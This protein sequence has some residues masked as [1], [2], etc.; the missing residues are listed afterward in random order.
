MIYRF[1]DYS[2][3]VEG[4]ELRRD[5]EAIPVEPQVFGLLACLIENRERVVS[6][7]DLI[8]AVWGG[9]IVSEAT[10]SS[11]ISFARQAVGDSGEAQAVIRTIPRR[12][13]RFVAEASAE[14]TIGDGGAGAARDIPQ[15][16]R[17]CTTG[18]EVQLAYSV[19]GSGP[20]LLKVANW[21]NHLEFDWESP[22]WRA[23]FQSLASYRQL[24][25]YDSRGVGLSDWEVEDFSFESLARDLETVVETSDP[26]PFALLGISQGAAVAIDYAT[27]N[28][29]R[30][31]HLIL[32]G[33]FAR[34]RNRRGNQEEAA[35]AEAFRT[36][37]RQGW[38]KET[39]VFRQMFASLYLPDAND[40]QVRW[41]TDMQ[42]IATSP[43]NAVR[44]RE[45][46]DDLDVTEKLA[47]VSTPTLILHS[48]REEVA[49]FSEARFMATR[50]KD[51]SFVALDSANHLV[52]QQEPAWRRAVDEIKR[53]LS[54]G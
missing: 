39:S 49:P 5:G 20:P 46:I 28:P 43:E 3:D 38:G 34:G 54:A 41:W 47:E 2:L 17:Y 44:L 22:I 19:A 27:R 18:D 14:D 12:G 7:D 37:M 16:I 25:R 4:F 21:L 8:E 31:S 53:F 6:K 48:E 29:E 36:I 40:E 10:L 24:I 45:S 33:G 42:R 11:R 50:I 51:A 9:R 13:F 52:L 30:V 26:P 1:G 32:W 15:T 35:R 23:L